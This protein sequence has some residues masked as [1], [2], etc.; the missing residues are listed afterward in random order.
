MWVNAFRAERCGRTGLYFWEPIQTVAPGRDLARP[1]CCY[2]RTVV[3]Y[4]EPWPVI[5][6]NGFLAEWDR[7]ETQWDLLG[8]RWT[9]EDLG[10][11][12]LAALV[13]HGGVVF[14]LV[15]GGVVWEDGQWFMRWRA[16][17]VDPEWDRRWPWIEK[18]RKE[19]DDV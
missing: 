9:E 4:K 8:Q 17:W 7:V 15:S 14:E 5:L 16:R 19:V 10:W 6:E 1:Y 11:A 2:L 18:R 13:L 3:F 12:S